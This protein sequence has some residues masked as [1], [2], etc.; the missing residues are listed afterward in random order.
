ME[1]CG[2]N[3]VVRCFEVKWADLGLAW[4]ADHH[5]DGEALSPSYCQV[6]ARPSTTEARIEL[7]ERGAALLSS[8][9][10]VLFH[11]LQMLLPVAP[12][13]YCVGKWHPP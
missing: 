9:K 2:N 8:S 12:K 6:P 3:Q 11:I 5:A 10:A 1:R 7:A 4:L 13:S